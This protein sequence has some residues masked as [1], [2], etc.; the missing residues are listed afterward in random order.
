MVDI[1][2]EVETTPPTRAKANPS[3][4]GG[5][6]YYEKNGN[7]HTTTLL[8]WP[9]SKY[10]AAVVDLQMAKFIA[11]ILHGQGYHMTQEFLDAIVESA[12]IYFNK[13]ADSLKT[14]TE[15]QRRT[16][17]S[18]NDLKYSFEVCGMDFNRLYLQYVRNQKIYRLY[19]R[20]LSRINQETEDIVTK[21]NHSSYDPSS[22]VFFDSQ[23]YE[24]TELVPK[25]VSKPQYVPKYLPEFPPDYTYQNTARYIE[26]LKDMEKLRLRL[27]EESR[28][29]EKSLYNIIDDEKSEW[30]KAIDLNDNYGNEEPLSDSPSPRFEAY[31]PPELPEYAED[32]DEQPTVKPKVIDKKFDFIEYAQKR[33][34]I[35]NRRE[36]EIET[37]KKK[38]Q[39]NIFMKAE[40]YFSPYAQLEI[41]ND[42]RKEFDDILRNELSKVINAVRIGEEKQK[43]DIEIAIKEKARRL[44]E[45]RKERE[46][47]NFGFEF[48]ENSHFGSDSDSD[49]IDEKQ[50]VF[51]TDGIQE[52]VAI[53]SNGNGTAMNG[54]QLHNAE[55]VSLHSSDISDMEMELKEVIETQN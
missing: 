50:V 36:Q 12:L 30:R 38:R 31:K 24:I 39:Q 3:V 25:E 35:K 21:W 37:R 29:T 32:E 34:L 20:K 27:V 6:L 45:Q 46:T 26:P 48:N 2:K 16:I 40:K 41:T 23:D 7:N 18:V 13:L 5:Q 9:I 33:K 51:A 44:E 53:I 4:V 17:P 1:T 10:E 42:V 43:V 15:L 28:L 52:D 19:S 47:I 49:D 14:F 8:T 54:A 11:I 22:E 55:N